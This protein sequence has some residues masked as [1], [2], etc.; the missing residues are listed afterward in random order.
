MYLQKRF[1]LL[2]LI[3]R[4]L[5]KKSKLYE[6]IADQFHIN[7]NE[8]DVDK[9]KNIFEQKNIVLDDKPIASERLV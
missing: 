7:Q 4:F 2:H 8:Y 1:R 3:M 5:V 6:D 9:L